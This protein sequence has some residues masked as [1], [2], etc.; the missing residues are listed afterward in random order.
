MARAQGAYAPDIIV[1]LTDGAN[2]TG[3][4]P[5]DAAAAGRRPRRQGLHD[6][7]RDG[8]GWGL[9][10]G[11][12]SPVRRRRAGGR[13]PGRRWRWWREAGGG[14]F[15]RGIDEATLQQVADATGGAYYPAE[16]ADQLQQVF[17]QLPTTLITRHEAVEMGVVFV[18]LALAA[19][20]A[21]SLFGRL[22]RPLP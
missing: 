5:A 2:N 9:R 6:R 10:P 22:W 11:L 13:V 15:R 16:S 20:A 19:A 3:P 18:G 4:E 14:G 21:A 12:R 8:R 17:E 1:L 7:L